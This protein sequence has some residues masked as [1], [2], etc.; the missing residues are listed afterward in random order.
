MY[1]MFS[2][3]F[4][5]TNESIR[6]CGYHVTI[7]I[8]PFCVF[9]VRLK[10]LEA[11][12]ELEF[13]SGRIMPCGSM[14]INYRDIVSV[15]D[16][17]AESFCSCTQH[18]E[19]ANFNATC[20]DI[21]DIVSAIKSQKTNKVLGPDNTHSIFWRKTAWSAH[22]YCTLLPNV[23]GLMKFYPFNSQKVSLLH[24]YQRTTQIN[25]YVNLLLS[26]GVL[27]SDLY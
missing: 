11:S 6:L 18:T 24:Y 27:K 21:L 26:P 19:H 9:D 1:R 23:F 13:F 10:S 2:G 17:K 20:A 12:E 3:F 5:H 15:T 14:E 25:K 8:D 7:S 22:S 4:L 16:R